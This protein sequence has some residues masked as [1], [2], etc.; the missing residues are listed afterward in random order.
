MFLEKGYEQIFHNAIMTCG[1]D[2]KS[3]I[4]TQIM[5]LK[6]ISA[7]Y[8]L[9]KSKKV[10]RQILR[11]Y[12]R[13][14]KILDP[15]AKEKIQTHLTSLQTSILQKDAHIADRLAHQLQETAKKL[16]PRSTVDKARDF[17][18]AIAVALVVA[19]VIRQMWFELYTIPTGSMRPTLKESDFLVVSKTDFGL[20][21][22]LQASHFYFNPAL[23]HRGQ[24]VVFT[25]ENMDISDSDTVYFYL[26][27]G[28]K[29]FVKRLI[30]KPGDTLYFY[31]GEMYGISAE[32]TEL[33]ELREAKWA[34]NLEHIPFIRF[35]GKVETPT[36]SQGLYS[37][38]IFYQMNQPVAR[39][40]V[41]PYGQI[42]G[43]MIHR[44]GHAPLA[45]YSDLWGF[46]NYAMSRLLTESQVE[47]IHPGALK[48]LGPG[49]LYLELTHHPSLK[50]VRLLR[51]DMN[52]MRPDL[53]VSVS[54]IPLSQDHLEQIANNM[55]TRRF[56]VENGAAYS[57][58]FDR[59]DP[60]YSR[61]FPKLDDVPNGTYEIQDGKATRVF[62][63][64]I[65]R[66]LPPEHP[67]LSKD[68]AR[69]QLLY[70]LGFEFLTQFQ[71]TKNSRAIP[72]RYAYFRDHELFLLG[73]PVL[74]KDDP[75]LIL[76]LKR[77][78][79]KQSISTS[80]HPYL[81]FDDAGP[82]ITKDGKLDTDFIRQYGLVI[83]EKMYLALGDNH[84]LSADSRQFGFVP[85]DNLK[86]GVSFLFSP[87]GHRWG[88]LPQPLHPH[89]IFPN[90]F[91]L[92]AAF[93]IAVG[94]SIYMRRKVDQP[95][96]L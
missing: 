91:V 10:L 2:V 34:Q 69:I 37:S 28:K 44:K 3:S 43:E 76:F 57:L 65:T 68:P 96:N 95:L 77:E 70:N 22:P 1:E 25:G 51:D 7:F 38:A 83:P 36:N 12:R 60:F 6:K 92:S 16:M 53:G 42:T 84:A 9:K 82:P 58:G 46:R 32:G 17:I 33:K 90:V 8:T 19:I 63:G 80:V 4:L 23:V 78:Y 72:A 21:I 24:I 79:Q 11:Q 85:Q 50:E 71:P 74:K 67:L 40:D 26:F 29:Q 27:P 15:H 59:Q 81:P 13:K 87:P 55:I 73:A 14:A 56:V 52:R 61:F 54:L 48:D 89:L 41:N 35:D 93:L 66:E 94:Y 31:G 88:R 62:W 47:Q 49:V 30:A 39:L 86:G 75:A 64:G 45:H 18:T 5:T 20:N